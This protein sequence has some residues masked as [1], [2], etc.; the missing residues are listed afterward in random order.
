MTVKQTIALLI[1][2]LPLLTL[3]QRI[4]PNGR[5]SSLAF[6]EFTTIPIDTAYLNITYQMDF[7][8]N[9]I[10]KT[11]REHGL[12]VLQ[13]GKN[14]SK[15]SDFYALKI[16]HLKK[17]PKKEKY[18][19]TAYGNTVLGMRRNRKYQ[20]N[21][22]KNYPQQKSTIQL[23][24]RFGGTYQYEEDNIKL[25]WKIQEDTKPILGYQCQKASCTFRGRDYTAWYTEEIPISDG[26]HLFNGLP[27]LI[28]QIEDSE[29]AYIF[30]AQGIDKKQDPIFLI[31]NKNTIK[32][33][34]EK[35]R[36]AEKNLADNPSSVI[37]GTMYSE[38]GKA[39]KTRES[40]LPYNPIE[41]E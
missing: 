30:T 11:K 8:P 37:K 34:R 35:A 31:A 1:L 20:T 5:P 39:I 26:P 33:T 6:S 14:T 32:T 3:A 24:L 29:Q 17:A 16:D 41:R 40:T 36:K 38:P 22:I 19:N 15:F 12:T 7:I 27:G 23:V 10:H 9:P 18:A 25:N 21:I 4:E 28:L 2:L 13:I